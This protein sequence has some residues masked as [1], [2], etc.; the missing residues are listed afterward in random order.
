MYDIRRI[1]RW[2]TGFLDHMLSAFAKHGRLNLT[3][4]CKG[5]LHIARGGTPSYP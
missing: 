4:H 3:L 5:D 2:L 1:P